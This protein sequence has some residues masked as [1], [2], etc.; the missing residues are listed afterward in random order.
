MAHIVKWQSQ[1]ARR[2]RSWLATIA[3]ARY[4]LENLLEFEPSLKRFVPAL[5]VELFPRAKRIAERERGRLTTIDGLTWQEVF[6]K[7]YG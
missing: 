2:S 4:E 6:D 1:P 5:L 3:N 7:D